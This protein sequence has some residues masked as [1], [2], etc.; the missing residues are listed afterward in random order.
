MMVMLPRLTTSGGFLL[1]AI[2]LATPT[3][4]NAAAVSGN[5]GRLRYEQDA[6][7]NRVPDFS[8]CG[9][10]GADREIPAAPVRVSVTPG[11]GDDGARIQA[12]LDQVAALPLA[13][14][15]LRG[16]VALA[17]GQFEIAGQL[18][19]AASGV[20]LRG[21]GALES[22]TTLVATG[23]DRRTVIRIAGVNDR[24]IERGSSVAVA[25]DYVPVG[26]LDL[27]AT[28]AAGFAVGDAM[29]VSR[30]STQ[31]WVRELGCDAFGVGWRP[32]SRDVRWDRRIVAIQGDVLTLDAPITTAIDATYGGATVAKYV[33]PGRIENVGVEDLRI[34]SE[35]D[36]DLPRDEDHAWFGVTLDNARDAWV[37]R[38]AFVGFAGG[39]VATWE[40]TSRVT[41]E[42]C[43]AT[44]PVSEVAG[45]RRQ[46]FYT[47][48]QQTLFLRC[49]ADEGR[50]DFC[51]GH[52]APGP[53]AFVNCVASRAHGDSGPIESWASGVLYDNVRIDGGSLILDNRW[54]SPP[55]AGWS[56][57]NC[58]LWNVQAAKVRAFKPPTANNWVLGAWAIF[59]GDGHFEGRS[60]FASPVSLY[61]AQLRER[62][63]DAAADRIG[64]FLLK[65]ESSTNPRLV[66][67]P[68]FVAR[69]HAPA[70][71]LIDVVEA[72]WREAMA[73]EV[74]A[75]SIVPAPSP[76][77][78]RA[79]EGGEAG[80]SAGSS[81]QGNT[82]PLTP[83]P[84]G[85]GNGRARGGQGLHVDNGWLVIDGKLVTGGL[86]DPQWWAGNNRPDEAPQFGP[87][88][89][90][91][92][93]GRT[94]LGLT[95]DL[96]QV[97]SDMQ[98]QGEAVYDHHYGLWYDLRRADHLHSRQE[99]ASCAVP[100]YEQPFARAG[101][102]EAWDGLSKYDLT[103]F[104][105]WYWQ[106][107]RDFAELCN[108]RGLVLVHQNYFQHN[109]LE[110]GAHWVDCPWRPVNNVNNTG[111]S[112]PPPFIGDK[113]IFIAHQFYDV[114]NEHRRE[115]HRGYI[116]QCLDGLAEQSNVIQMTSA[117]YSGPLEF[118]QFWLDVVAEWEA[119]K[120]R[121]VI[122]GLSAPKDVQDAILAD[123]KRAAAVDVIDI[124]YWAYTAGGGTY[125]PG[126]GL[127]LAPRQHQRQGGK[128]AGGFGEIARA[129][130]EYRT[131][132]PGK[133]VTYFA[134]MHC[135]SRHDGWAVLMG[136]GSLADVRGLPAELAALVPTLTPLAG[137]AAGEGQWCLGREGRDYL[138]ASN[139]RARELSLTL[140]AGEYRAKWINTRSGEIADGERVTSAGG[141]TPVEGASGILW[142]SRVGD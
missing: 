57:A 62:A 65:P 122:V 44:E 92:V 140:P 11:E 73:A 124:R 17:A 54:T 2:L 70:R 98:A 67:V 24:R 87:N 4:S 85:E 51:V 47:Q 118:T 25:D 107:L 41:V 72:N 29:L 142:L 22:G 7:G 121:D 80:T 125:A 120:G 101:V 135:P 105:K 21:A 91:F 19:I 48:G 127:N 115:L 1:L 102:G 9:Y 141:T 34:V 103:K 30:P 18:R 45:W 81:T 32:G 119:E 79:G 96:E 95:T 100:F 94:G 76:F 134:E 104:N 50:R 123:E 117:E 109:I 33:W 130:H 97:A 52:C 10:A 56:A 37:R 55:G 27:T 63:G 3:P 26:A 82:L 137:V 16:T 75:S 88:I 28:S 83:P 106:R 93:P 86:V 31:E 78:G 111:F 66:E 14:D 40:T 8:A 110:A 23:D 129:V 133:A 59:A 43:A 12:A 90:R 60:D 35:H 116:R 42:D 13:A 36:A 136:G 112:E 132:F 84:R 6:Q 108:E 139:D 89:T 58:V 49:W 113:R 128:R 99:D 131:K 68:G 69:S 64:P 20:V 126:G 61:Q 71:Q 46:S 77:E 5:N 53:N 39:A 15:G 114:T 138:V 38:V 74:E